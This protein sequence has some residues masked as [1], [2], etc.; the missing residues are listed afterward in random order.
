VLIT[1]SGIDG[2][3]KSTQ[4]DRLK[5]ALEKQGYNVKYLWARGGYTPCFEWLKGVMRCVLRRKLPQPGNSPQRQKVFQ[6]RGVSEIWLSIAIV[7]LIFFWCIWTRLYTLLGFVVVCDRYI[8]DTE[9][10]FRRNFDGLNIDEKKLWRLLRWMIPK[11]DASFV[12]WL[13]IDEVLN[14]QRQKLE[15]FPDDRE[16][17]SWR[18]EQYADE[19]LFPSTGFVRV[20]C[21][22]AIDSV[23]RTV[24]QHIL[25]LL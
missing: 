20:D 25:R 15:P 4:I 2:A 16:T 21:G 19:L 14:R 8:E 24:W 13:P 1:F 12:L 11:P 3:G 7:D 18:L 17:L 23:E 6:R 10:D 22:D 5:T 9:L